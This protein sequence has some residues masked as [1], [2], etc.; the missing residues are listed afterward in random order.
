MG[1]GCPKCF[2]HKNE[3]ECKNIIEKLTGEHFTR[4][5]PKFLNKLEYDCYNDDL[6]LALEYNGIQH[7]EYS[8]FFHSNNRKKFEKQ[9]ENDK[10]KKELSHQN[11]IYLIVVPHWI[12]DKEKFI[13]EEYQNYLFLRNN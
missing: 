9:K 4:E 7:Y 10:L 8:P 3:N 12:L 13:N 5:R 6:K 2:V 11:R 1:Q